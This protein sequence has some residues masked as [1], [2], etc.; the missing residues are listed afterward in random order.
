MN[1]DILRKRNIKICM[2]FL[3]IIMLALI[4]SSFTNFNF[5]KGISSVSDAFKWMFTQFIPNKESL[6]KLPDIM[7]KLIE[8]ILLSIC[9]ATAAG[10]LALILGVL[11]SKVTKVNSIFSVISRGIASI[12]RNIPDSVW[13][14]IFLLSF[15]QNI[16]TGFFALFFASLGILTRAFIET[17]DEASVSA[18]EGLESTGASKLQIVVMAIIPSSL[19]EMMSWL[20]YMIE[21]NIRS[22]TLIGI[23]TGTGIGFSFNLYYKCMN[24]N[25]ASLVV[26]LI[27][28]AVIVIEIVSNK[29]RRLII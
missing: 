7:K 5:I 16:L 3:I 24:Y 4:S 18:V 1:I 27:V 8:T 2:V 25:C 26:L 9:A 21:T 13:A 11:G 17:M 6:A 22:S 12:S 29:V 10:I 19:S 15:G 20:L 23:L 14:M 28:L